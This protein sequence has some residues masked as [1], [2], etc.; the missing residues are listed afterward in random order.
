MS[1]LHG[2]D[3]RRFDESPLHLDR[4]DTIEPISDLPE[5]LAVIELALRSPG[6]AK[7]HFPDYRL[8]RLVGS[9]L[10]LDD[11]DVAQLGI[12]VGVEFGQRPGDLTRPFDRHLRQVI[13]SYGLETL[14]TNNGPGIYHHA[15]RPAGYDFNFDEV[16]P[17]GME[18]WRA[19]YRAMPDERQMLAASII[20]LYRAGKD[21]RWLRRVP[22]TWHAADAIRHMQLT[23]VLVE[24]VRLFALYP[25][26]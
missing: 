23:G 5:P 6:A 21:N 16:I 1:E 20:W 7:E 26:W 3:A 12:I 19:D 24:W 4:P 15:I 17:V 25:G 18:Q 22:C 10:D 8:T 2:D 9:R 13:A 14:F 11:A